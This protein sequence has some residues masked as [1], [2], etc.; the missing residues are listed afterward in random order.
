MNQESGF[1]FARA[2]RVTPHESEEFRSTISEQFGINLKK[3]YRQN[4][5]Y[6]EAM[7]TSKSD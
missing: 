7:E 1:P 3:R 5:E 2:R 4:K 6:K